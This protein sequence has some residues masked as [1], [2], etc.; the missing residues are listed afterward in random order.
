MAGEFAVECW[1]FAPARLGSFA[2]YFSALFRCH[3][4]GTRLAAFQAAFAAQGDGGLIFGGIFGVI[5]RAVFDLVGEDIPDQ[6]TE[7]D[8]IAGALKA[9]GCHRGSMPST[10]TGCERRTGSNCTTTPTG[11]G[12][13][14][15][16]LATPRLPPRNVV[17]F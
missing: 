9:L 3:F 6:L 7:L 2:G 10:A 16:A 8:R 4:G 15:R 14:R 13:V 1:L 12:P 5:W 11:S 17:F